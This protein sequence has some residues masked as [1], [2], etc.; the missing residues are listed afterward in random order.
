MKRLYIGSIGLAAAIA[1]AAVTF[2]TANYSPGAKVLRP[3]PTGSIC[4]L[5]NSGSPAL[6][7]PTAQKAGLPA[8]RLTAQV[9]YA[10]TCYT[11]AGPTC[12]MTVLVPSGSPCTCYYPTY[13]L[14]GVAY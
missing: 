11:Y 5:T 9:Q 14:N 3:A 13:W 7:S 12:P 2:A 6:K 10:T 1:L 4:S 8:N